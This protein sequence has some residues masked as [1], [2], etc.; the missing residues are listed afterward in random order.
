MFTHRPG[1]ALMSADVSV[2]HRHTPNFWARRG[3][4]LPSGLGE[5]PLITGCSP[6]LDSSGDL[7]PPAVCVVFSDLTLAVWMTAPYQS[8]LSPTR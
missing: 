5:A 4:A 2:T 1:T 7:H 3:P 6:N 8:S